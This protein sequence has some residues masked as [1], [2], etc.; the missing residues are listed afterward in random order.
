VADSKLA[1]FLLP[2]I[3]AAFLCSAVSSFCHAQESTRFVR[4]DVRGKAENTLFEGAAASQIQK[5]IF[6]APHQGNQSIPVQIQVGG[7]P[8]IKV[9]VFGVVSSRRGQ[10]PLIVA[11]SS[12]RKR[13]PLSKIALTSNV[14]QAL[15]PEPPQPPSGGRFERDTSSDCQGISPSI[16]EAYRQALANAYPPGTLTDSVIC[17]FIRNGG[18]D[19]DDNPSPDATPTPPSD[20]KPSQT[21]SPFEIQRGTLFF[22]KDGCSS[23]RNYFLLVEVDLSRVKSEGRKTSFNVGAAAQTVPFQGAKASVLKP[24]S[25]GKFSPRPLMLMS[26]TGAYGGEAMYLSRWAKNRLRS[27]ES[28]KVEDYV[29]ARGR[30]L[31]RAVIDKYL[32]GGKGVFELYNQASGYGVCFDLARRRQEKNGY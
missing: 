29:Y 32:R 16:I 24:E 10:T 19:V 18:N 5:V 4:F 31:A 27:S 28:I 3:L 26:T 14:S 15:S 1:Q 9:K 23:T 6:V 13:Y 7:P 21:F 30:T 17:A 22:Q 12:Q 2:A 20:L 11:Q 25:D 8:G